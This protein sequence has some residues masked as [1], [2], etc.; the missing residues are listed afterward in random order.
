MHDENDESVITDQTL[1]FSMSQCK[2]PCDC[3]LRVSIYMIHSIIIAL[4]AQ[5]CTIAIP[6]Q[7]RILS[8]KTLISLLVSLV[9]SLT[10]I[11]HSK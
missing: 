9:Q 5:C 1:P 10:D 7:G 2:W 4:R 11:S 6:S 8:R 3:I